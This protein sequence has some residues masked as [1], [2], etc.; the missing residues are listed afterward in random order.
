VLTDA[1][2]LSCGPQSNPLRDREVFARRGSANPAF[3]MKGDDHGFHR[4]AKTRWPPLN[5]G[6]CA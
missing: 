6:D 1:I 3:N 4:L 2:A 5:V